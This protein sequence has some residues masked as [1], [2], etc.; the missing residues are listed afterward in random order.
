M[1]PLIGPYTEVISWL[2]PVIEIMI[3]IIL[4]IPLTKIKGLFF[5]TIL[6]IFFT[7]YVG[8]I[9]T[10][11]NHLPCTCGGF[12]QKLSWKQHLILNTSFVLFGLI[13]LSLARMSRKKIEKTNFSYQN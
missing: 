13:A 6:M 1:M 5:A 2:L 9:M 8:Y 3:A 11:N 7:G 12:L 10:S 4:I